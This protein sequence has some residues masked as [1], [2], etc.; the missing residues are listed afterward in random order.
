MKKVVEEA[1]A[2]LAEYIDKAS[3]ER[4][5]SARNSWRKWMLKQSEGGGRRVRHTLS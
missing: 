3:K 2:V 4:E 5:K 1:K